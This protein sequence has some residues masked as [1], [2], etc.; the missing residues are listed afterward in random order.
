VPL[1][2][3]TVMRGSGTSFRYTASGRGEVRWT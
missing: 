2:Q 1:L 3:L